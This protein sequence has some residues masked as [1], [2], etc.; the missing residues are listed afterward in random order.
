MGEFVRFEVDGGIGTIRLDRPPMN[1]LNAQVQ[2]ELHEAA[3]EASARTDVRAVVIYGG[4]KVFA[5]G[6]DIKEMVTADYASMVERAAPLQAAFDAL[7]RIPKPTVAAITGYA[8]GGGCE[9]A[10]TAD[11]RVCG[12][13]AKLGQPEILLGIIP[14][15]GGRRR[16]AGR[17]R[18]PSPHSAAAAATAGGPMR[19][20]SAVSIGR[21][22]RSAPGSGPMSVR[23]WVSASHS[24]RASDAVMAGTPSGGLTRRSTA[25]PTPSTPGIAEQMEPRTAGTSIA[26]ARARPSCI[27]KDVKPASVVVTASPR[28]RR[29]GSRRE[30]SGSSNR[31]IPLLPLLRDQHPSA[32]P[33]TPIA[34]PSHHPNG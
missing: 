2:G 22:V 26:E 29:S 16:T 12:D 33:T 32:E 28:A 24:A 9:L 13:N 6:A 1:A 5:A 8:L 21:Q 4:E 30:L 20:R 23:C 34:D 14:G 18:S 10:L 31:T 15:A 27:T 3:T 7:A 17:A 25:P 19:A 11:F